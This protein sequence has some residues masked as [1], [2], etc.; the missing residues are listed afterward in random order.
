MKEIQ[1]ETRRDESEFLVQRGAELN[2]RRAPEK[3][4]PPADHSDEEDDERK[5]HRVPDA[6][7]EPA[8]QRS[9]PCPRR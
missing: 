4:G 2:A 3:P 8:V 5:R 7:K 1:V 9:S 6:T